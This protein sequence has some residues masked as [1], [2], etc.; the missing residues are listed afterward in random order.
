MKK[1]ERKQVGDRG[2]SVACAFLV[3]EGY[4]ILTR[5]WR[6]SLGEIDIIAQKENLVIFVEVKTNT[7]EYNSAFAPEVR[8]DHRKLQKIYHC[9]LAFLQQSRLQHLSWRIDIISVIL[10][11]EKAKITHFKNVLS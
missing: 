5:N 8:A 9:A 11:H 4:V 6:I 10:Q 3:R 1:T 2:E 7:R